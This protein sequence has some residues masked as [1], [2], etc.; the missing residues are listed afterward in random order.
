MTMYEVYRPVEARSLHGIVYSRHR[1][2][3]A[4]AR[5]CREMDARL[6]R[7]PGMANSWVET[8]IRALEAGTARR[9]TEAECEATR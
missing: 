9:L 4:A 6:Q 8:S 5:R 7:Q 1:T 3:A 2:P